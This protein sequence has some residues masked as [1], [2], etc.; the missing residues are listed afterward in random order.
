MINLHKI[1]F[2]LF[3]L[4]IKIDNLKSRTSSFNCK[5][6][7]N[8]FNISV[9]ECLKINDDDKIVKY[10]HSKLNPVKFRKEK[11]HKILN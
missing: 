2:E 6:E 11:I 9:L 10:I 1:Q 4:N 3:K 8:I 5:F 7:E